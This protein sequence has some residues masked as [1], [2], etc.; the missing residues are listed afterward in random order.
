MSII[1]TL[2][3]YASLFSFLFAQGTMSTD[4]TEIS[5]AEASLSGFGHL[6][7]MPLHE[8][9]L[10]ED[11]QDESNQTPPTSG[12]SDDRSR[13]VPHRPHKRRHNSQP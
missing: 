10:Q 13:S 2:L 4:D 7:R 6:L 8:A 9:E 5:S 12:N 3:I 1:L 11:D